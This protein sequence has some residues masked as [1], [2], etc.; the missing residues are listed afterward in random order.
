MTTRKMTHQQFTAALKRHNMKWTGFLGYVEIGYGCSCSV[1]NV[2]KHAG[3]RAW[4][5]YLIREQEKAE[6]RAS[7]TN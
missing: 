2:G 4:L 5:A 3:Y 6:E 1:L 7:V